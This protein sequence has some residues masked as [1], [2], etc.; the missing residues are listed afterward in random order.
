MDRVPALRAVWSVM[1]TCTRQQ[2]CVKPCFSAARGMLPG[3]CLLKSSVLYREWHITLLLGRKKL[4]QWGKTKAGINE[5]T[6]IPEVGDSVVLESIGTSLPEYKLTVTWKT[7]I[8][9]NAMHYSF[10]KS[11]GYMFRPQTVI[12]RPYNNYSQLVLCTFWDP[13]M[14]SSKCIKI[15]KLSEYSLITDVLKKVKIFDWDGNRCCDYTQTFWYF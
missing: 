15:S 10:I 3:L 6:W 8:I 7:A 9:T 2:D 4:V 1:V 11:D 12:I 14:F 13:V 5:R